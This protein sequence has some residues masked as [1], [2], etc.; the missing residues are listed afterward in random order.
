MIKLPLKSG[1][2]ICIFSKDITVQKEVK[3]ARIPN[4]QEMAIIEEKIYVLDGK[5]T[6]GG[7]LIDLPFDEVI[8]VIENAISEEL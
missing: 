2:E 5:H 7:W 8:K 4:S 3:K 1:G 6:N